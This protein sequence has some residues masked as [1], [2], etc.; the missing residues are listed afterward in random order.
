MVDGLKVDLK[1]VVERVLEEAVYFALKASS[2]LLYV[3]FERRQD[4]GLVKDNCQVT[5][6]RD[7]IDRGSEMVRSLC[8]GSITTLLLEE[9]WAEL[10]FHVHLFCNRGISA[11]TE[12]IGDLS[13]GLFGV[14]VDLQDSKCLLFG[15]DICFKYLERVLA[16]IFHTLRVNIDTYI[17]FSSFS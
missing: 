12:P 13:D 7:V 15:Q 11:F 1:H 2:H 14:N 10:F 17:A 9:L 6:R 3:K 8:R 16:C 5:R 4:D